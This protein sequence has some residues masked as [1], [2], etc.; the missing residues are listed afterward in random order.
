MWRLA[1]LGFG[2]VQA[3]FDLK[4]AIQWINDN[5]QDIFETS[6]HCLDALKIGQEIY[7]DCGQAVDVKNFGALAAWGMLEALEYVKDPVVQEIVKSPVVQS[8]KEKAMHRVEAG[9][10]KSMDAFCQSECQNRVG[11][12]D[13]EYSLCSGSALCAAMSANL[14]F[15]KCKGVMEKWFPKSMH[16]QED[17]ICAKEG[18]MYCQEFWDC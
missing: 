18:E 14:D 4:G 1:V 3:Q 13:K 6:S 2:V 11:G 12:F 10:H 8:F 16:I 9:T 5:S 15:E 7:Q 17:N